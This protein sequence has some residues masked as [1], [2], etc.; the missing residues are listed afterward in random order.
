M[1]KI[2]AAPRAPSAVETENASEEKITVLNPV[3]YPPKISK[4]ARGAAAG[5]PRWQDHLS[6]RLPLRRLGR[7]AEAGA[8]LVRRAHAER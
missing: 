6:G 8:E 5:E 1:N 4:K 3:G 2:V 7:A